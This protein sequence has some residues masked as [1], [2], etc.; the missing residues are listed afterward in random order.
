MLRH[1]F[2]QRDIRQENYTPLMAAS[3]SGRER[4]VR[5][6]ID[7]GAKVNATLVSFLEAFY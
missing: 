4:T 1:S 2:E 3:K 7:L 6:L 5:K